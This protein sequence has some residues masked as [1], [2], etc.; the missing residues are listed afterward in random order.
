MNTVSW[1]TRIAIACL[2]PLL[3][4][5]NLSGFEITSGLVDHQVLQRGP[6]GRRRSG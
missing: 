4:G 1:T 6:D 3:T 2:L 5:A